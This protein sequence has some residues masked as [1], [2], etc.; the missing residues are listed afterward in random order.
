MQ[1][2]TTIF[3]KTPEEYEAKKTIKIIR[4]DQELPINFLVFTVAGAAVYFGKIYRNGFK[5]AFGTMLFPMLMGHT[6]NR[7]SR[8]PMIFDE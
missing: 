1:K 6:Y 5:V 3:T 2:F 8:Q 7:L 4:R